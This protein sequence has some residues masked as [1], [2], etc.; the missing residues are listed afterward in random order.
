MVLW[1]LSVVVFL[2]RAK[3]TVVRRYRKTPSPPSL[4]AARPLALAQRFTACSSLVALYLLGLP[5]PRAPFGLSF[6][7]FQK[8]QGGPRAQ[9]L[10]S[11]VASQRPCCPI[12]RH[13]ESRG[14]REE[15]IINHEL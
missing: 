13:V 3:K 15:D 7:L 2:T 14:E 1:N 6:F 11:Q 9:W 5:P 10:D 4:R 12:E 8:T